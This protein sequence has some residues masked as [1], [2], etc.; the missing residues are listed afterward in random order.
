MNTARFIRKVREFSALKRRSKNSFSD[1]VLTVCA[2]TFSKADLGEGSDAPAE[3]MQELW[4]I[5]TNEYAPLDLQ[6]F[7]KDFNAFQT[8]VL[9]RVDG[10]HPPISSGGA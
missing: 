2:I 7:P 1:H 6:N 4:R 3:Q 5:V 8:E 10:L 9:R